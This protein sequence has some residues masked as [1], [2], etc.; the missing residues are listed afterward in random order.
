MPNSASHAALQLSSPPTGRFRLFYDE[1]VDAGVQPMLNA[2]AI[3]P[4]L[5]AGGC[6]IALVVVP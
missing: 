4:D 3:E 2:A 6:H 1:I 5:Q